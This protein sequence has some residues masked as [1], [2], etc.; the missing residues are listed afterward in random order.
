[1]VKAFISLQ[2]R[3]GNSAHPLAEFLQRHDAVFAR[4][5]LIAWVVGAIIAAALILRIRAP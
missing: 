4:T 3:I 1:M 2:A 5:M